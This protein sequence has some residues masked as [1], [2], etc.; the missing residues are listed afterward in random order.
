MQE[1]KESLR[2]KHAQQPHSRVLRLQAE[3]LPGHPGGLLG[4]V[5]VTLRLLPHVV[6]LHALPDRA[7]P[8][9]QEEEGDDSCCEGGP[10][11][12][13]APTRTPE[14]HLVGLDEVE[15]FAVNSVAVLKVPAL[16]LTPS[17]QVCK[18]RSREDFCTAGLKEP[19]SFHSANV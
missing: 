3:L 17:T 15:V 2:E 8:Y 9:L 18:G 4:K 13:P 10:T 19:I 11:Q 12:T 6:I 16:F 7:R 1:K 5:L 14:P